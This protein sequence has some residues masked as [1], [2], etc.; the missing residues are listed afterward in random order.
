MAEE[1]KS[2]DPALAGFYEAI[3]RTNVE[4]ITDEML[5]RLSRDSSDSESCDIE[6]DNDDAEDRTWRP[7]HVVFQ[8]SS[9]KKGHIEAMKGKYFH[10][11]SIVS[12]SGENIVPLPEADEVVVFKSFM[13]VGLRFPLHK[14]LVEV[15][16]RF[17]IYLHQLTPEAL[18]KVIIFIWAIKSRGLE[19]YADCF[20][21][22]H[23]L[24]YQTKATVKEQYHNNFECYNFVYRSDVRCH[25]PTFRKN[26]RVRG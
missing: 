16:N 9:V 21:N 4:K 12:A 22:I 19:L 10:D 13:K 18:I 14:M 3:E 20:C 7:S 8:K 6:S 2:V 1:N 23:K 11:I 5:A 26:G 15:L 25:V 17:E 24:S